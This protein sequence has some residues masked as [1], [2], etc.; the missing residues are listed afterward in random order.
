MFK[1]I[2]IKVYANLPE[3][4]RNEIIAVIDKKPYS[5]NSAYLEINNDTILGKKVLE[6]M[7]KMGLLKNE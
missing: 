1:G 7:K 6:K 3:D 5:W 2:F 4:V